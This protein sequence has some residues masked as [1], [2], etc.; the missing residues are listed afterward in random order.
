MIAQLKIILDYS[1]KVEDSALDSKIKVALE[2]NED[3]SQK[4]DALLDKIGF[5]PKDSLSSKKSVKD[6]NKN[7]ESCIKSLEKH[8]FEQVWQE[9]NRVKAALLG[10]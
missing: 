5:C 3:I 7:L 2:F 10:S 8:N 6:F 4:A 1:K 9:F